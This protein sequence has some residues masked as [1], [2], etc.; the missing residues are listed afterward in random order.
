MSAF[1]TA[2]FAVK[3]FIVEDIVELGLVVI[4]GGVNDVRNF[5]QD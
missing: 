2:T 5:R 3:I 4:R 1:T